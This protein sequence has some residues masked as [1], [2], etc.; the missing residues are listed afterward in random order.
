MG[1]YRQYLILKGR[2]KS[3]LFRSIIPRSLR[4]QLGRR[5]FLLSVHSSVLQ[6]AQKR[7]KF[8]H[9]AAQE[10]YGYLKIDPP[11]EKMTIEGIKTI[12]A[13]RL[14]VYRQL[15][16]EEGLDNFLLSSED[17]I[18][19]IESGDSIPIFIR[20]LASRTEIVCRVGG[21]GWRR[22]PKNLIYR[23]L[24]FAPKRRAKSYLF[25]SVFYTPLVIHAYS[26]KIINL[27]IL[28]RGL[29]SRCGWALSAQ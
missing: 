29:G 6:V 17:L 21:V 3:Y 23:Q 5:A 19:A 7:A 4:P 22:R 10:I 27:Y 15:V 20:K 1:T 14:K 28:G 9:G 13:Y 16:E 24:I 2:S 25:R 12:L 8:L 26:S 11:M 18:A